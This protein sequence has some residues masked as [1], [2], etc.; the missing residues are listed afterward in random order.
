MAHGVTNRPRWQTETTHQVEGHNRWVRGMA[1][2]ACGQDDWTR[3]NGKH[4]KWNCRPCR[5]A[6]VARWNADLFPRVLAAYGGK[7]A[8][9]GETDPDMLVVD[10]I[11][12][13]GA[14][15]RRGLAQR[16]GYPSLTQK[17]SSVQVHADLIRRGFPNDVQILCAN[18]NLKKERERQRRLTAQRRGEK[19]V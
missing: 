12:D 7:C 17:A 18:H 6:G 16:L 2:A 10:H 1:H 19:A 13:D 14:E 4:P 8:E 11:N 9:C 15:Q 3:V 5:A